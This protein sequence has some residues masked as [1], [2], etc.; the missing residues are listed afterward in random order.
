MHSIYVGLSVPKKFKV[1]SF[2][3]RWAESRKWF[4]YFFAS[5][6]FT[7][8]PPTQERDFYMVHEAAGNMVRFI[9]EDHFKDHTNIVKLYKFQF[10]ENDIKFMELY[11]MMS[12]GTPYAFMENVGI[13]VVRVVRILT[14]RRIGNPFSEGAKAQKCSELVMRNVMLAHLENIGLTLPQLLTAVLERTGEYIPEDLDLI[15]VADLYEMLETLVE[16]GNVRRAEAVIPD[17][18]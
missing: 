8:Y 11:S 9:A 1:G 6:V 14:G 13:A 18:P 4:G 12:C 3:I 16:M 15:G 10:D 7:L 2:L 5:H 17:K